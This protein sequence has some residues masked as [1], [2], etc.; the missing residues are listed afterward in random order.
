MNKQ[1]H[2][3]ALTSSYRLFFDSDD[4]DNDERQF[5]SWIKIQRGA[6]MESNV[7]CF[8]TIA[9]V[10]GFVQRTIQDWITTLTLCCVSWLGCFGSSSLALMYRIHSMWFAALRQYS[11]TEYTVCLGMGYENI[12]SA[13]I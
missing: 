9:N 1:K 13:S 4:N 8:A 10:F 12:T 7:I 5:K 6:E 11:M 3:F 2:T